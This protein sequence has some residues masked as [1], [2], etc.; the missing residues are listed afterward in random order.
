MNLDYATVFSL[1]PY[2]NENV[3]TLIGICLLIDI[4]FTGEK[5]ILCPLPE[6]RSGWVRT[7]ITW[8]GELISATRYSAE[9]D[10]VPANIIFNLFKSIIFL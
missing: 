8:C 5:W 6:Q 1:A 3:V 9:K 10:S 2:M 7:A 4:I